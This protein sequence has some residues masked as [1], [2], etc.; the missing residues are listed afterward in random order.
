M[1]CFGDQ[2]LA[3]CVIIS[4]H[5]VAAMVDVH[6]NLLDHNPPVFLSLNNLH[7]F[8]R[9]G[10]GS[11]PDPPVRHNQVIPIE[12][13]S[14]FQPSIGSDIQ[15]PIGQAIFGRTSAVTQALRPNDVAGITGDYA[16]ISQ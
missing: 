9:R 3:R 10:A 4:T 6:L 15:A 12:H 8:T 5:R 16:G 7:I 2:R 1:H 13:M 14:P 11:N